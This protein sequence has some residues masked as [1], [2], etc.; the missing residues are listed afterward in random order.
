[1]RQRTPRASRDGVEVLQTDDGSAARVRAFVSTRRGGVSPP[2]FASLNAGL[3]VGDGAN[4][5]MENRQ[6]IARA[7]GVRPGS[8]VFCRQVHAAA[9]RIVSDEHRGRGAHDASAAIADVDGLA[10]AH[11]DT[12]LAIL[13]ADCV[14]VLVVDSTVPAIGAAHAGWRGTAMG[15]AK[16]LVDVMVEGLGARAE[17]L[18]V[19]LGPSI[20]ARRYEVG[21]DVVEAVLESTPREAMQVAGTRRPMVTATAD[22]R[23]TLDL[24]EANARQLRM[25]GVS[26]ERIA[27]SEECTFDRA[28]RYYSFRRDGE[29]TGRFMAGIFIRPGEV[30]R[31]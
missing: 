9:V 7:A 14:P 19:Y 17:R 26:P 2:P 8:F 31:P 18:Q 20:S 23:F 11:A 1:M 4:H 30:R 28:D 25:A 13:V 10:T 22:G 5:V 21:R 27:R 24:R 16:N 6:R 3:H 12:C 29:P 15:I